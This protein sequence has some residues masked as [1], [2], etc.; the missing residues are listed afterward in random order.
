MN[1]SNFQTF[2]LSNLLLVA[3]LAAFAPASSPA[4]AAANT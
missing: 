4:P 2:K 3:A 1:F